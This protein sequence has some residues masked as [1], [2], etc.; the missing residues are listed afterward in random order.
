[1]NWF[2]YLWRKFAGAAANLLPTCKQAA[3]LQSDAL[4][5]RPCLSQRI[6]LRLHLVLCRWCRRYGRQIAFLRVIGKR[7]AEERDQM[8]VP[9]LS[10]EARDRIR[11]RLEL[12]G[13]PGAS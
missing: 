10:T 8:P 4:D 12:E 3:R 11:R 5:R 9:S 2:L 1:M 7:C 13:K 6:G